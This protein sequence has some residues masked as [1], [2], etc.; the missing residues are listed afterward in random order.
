MSAA[1]KQT[2]PPSTALPYFH[3]EAL[4]FLRGLK[5]NNRREWFEARRAIFERELK[6]P[7]LALIDSVTSGMMDYAPDHIREARRIMLRIYR[8]TRFSADKSPYKHHIAAWWG[9]GGMEK[10]SGAGYYLHLS[11]TELI[12]AAGVYMPGKDQL[13][14]I[15]RYLLDHS[16]EFGALLEDRKMRRSFA[17][18]D[19]MPLARAPKGFPVDHPAAEWIRW[20]QWGVTAALP[21]EAALTSQLP[22]TV[23]THFAL[24]APL[25]EFLNRAI[26]SAAPPKARASF[27]ARPPLALY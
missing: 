22:R 10:T 12:L 25:V 24:A 3:E 23:H 20:R 26:L 15:R 21:A 11:G 4:R 13:L 5:R 7:M 1:R 2:T 8:D 19:P 6:A 27:T 16:D 9:R 18:H 17:L 14:A